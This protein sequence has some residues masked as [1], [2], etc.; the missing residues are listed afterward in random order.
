VN[1]YIS[2][3]RTGKALNPSEQEVTAREYVESHK[4]RIVGS[5]T[6]KVAKPADW[7]ALRRAIEMAVQKDATLVIAKLDRLARNVA[8][9]SLLL[10]SGVK[11]VCCD[12]P[13]ANHL[14]IHIMAA[15]AQDE[16]MRV[17]Q[18]TRD[19]L[20]AAKARGVKLGSNRKDHWKGREHKRGWRQAVAASVAKRRERAAE[21]YKFLLPEIKARRERGETL[22]EIIEWLNSTGHTTTVGK[23][24]T[25]TALWRIIERYLGKEYLGNNIRKFAKTDV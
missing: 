3:Y 23:P 1:K 18:R 15:V 2:Y 20:A 25:Q 16:S 22:P 19:S 12:L 7:P 8:V 24:F 21:S 4:G 9:T 6:E 17:R 11:F 5:F 10:K 13:N 14:T